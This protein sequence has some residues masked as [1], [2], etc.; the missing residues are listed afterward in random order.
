VRTIAHVFPTC[1]IFRELPPDQERLQAGEPDFTNM[2][3]FCRKTAEQPITF[4]R[5][6]AQDRLMSRVREVFLDPKNEVQQLDFLE[7]D[8]AVI[9]A[10]NNTGDLTKWHRASAAGHWAIMRGL[11]PP[12][13]WEKW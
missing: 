12:K 13:I 2:V 11:I 9:L 3:I 7:D 1:R 8:S 4:R 6:R 5:S 10:R